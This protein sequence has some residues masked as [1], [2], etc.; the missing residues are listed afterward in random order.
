MP[1]WSFNKRICINYPDAYSETVDSWRKE[2]Y[3]S[4]VQI[5]IFRERE[6]KK[7]FGNAF[8]TWGE[9]I[10]LHS[11]YCISTGNMNILYRM[12]LC[13]SFPP[14]QCMLS[15]L[16]VQHML[17]GETFSL[18]RIR[19]LNWKKSIWSHYDQKC[20]SRDIKRGSAFI[21]HKPHEVAQSLAGNSLF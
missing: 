9:I 15:C 20:L 2:A 17:F 6:G 8:L 12:L 19:K 5:S 1:T 21:F 4:C 13:S 10:I 14:V 18:L 7:P 3:T 11:G 16:K